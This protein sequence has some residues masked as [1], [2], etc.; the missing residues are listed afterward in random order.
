[1]SNYS[2]AQPGMQMYGNALGLNG[3][4]GSQ[5]AMDAFQKTNPGY[6]FQLEQGNNSVLAN[7]AK[8]GQLA[9]GNT[10]LDLQK[11][12][13]GLANQ[14]WNGWVNQLQPY[15]NQGNVAA[16]GIAGVDTG[17]GNALN[18]SWTNQGNMQY[19]ADTSI[20]NANANAALGNL[21]ASANMWGLGTGLLGLGA[22]GGGSL[23][24][25]LFNKF[26]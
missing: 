11:F 18:Q 14:T 7:Q 13:Q 15:L 5:A 9:S 4:Q 24:G 22:Q 25:N 12:G 19:G 1:M 8:S 20:G 10:N 3:A 17:L 16:S 2:G 23:G 21:N 6:Q 26:L